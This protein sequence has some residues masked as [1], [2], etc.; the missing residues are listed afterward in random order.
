MP[1]WTMHERRIVQHASHWRSILPVLSRHSR[2]SIVQ[3]WR[4]CHTERAPGWRVRARGPQTPDEHRMAV[5]LANLR[6]IVQREGSSVDI[7][8]ILDTL[9]AVDWRALVDDPWA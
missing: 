2:L 1:A 4:Q 5:L 9:R 8:G 6:Q 3:A 7:A